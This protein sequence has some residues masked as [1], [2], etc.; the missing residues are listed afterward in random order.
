MK[1]SNFYLSLMKNHSETNIAECFHRLY[2]TLNYERLEK[3]KL[4]ANFLYET[5]RVCGECYEMFRFT[6]TLM[7]GA[8][9]NKKSM[10]SQRGSTT[11][12]A[13]VLEENKNVIRNIPIPSLPKS[14]T[15]AL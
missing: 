2:P 10:R 15:S 3:R 14:Q 1:K 6:L 8:G 4:D 12:V 5:F 13:V 7:K 11:C 9:T